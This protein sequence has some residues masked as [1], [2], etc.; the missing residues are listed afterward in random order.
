[1]ALVL[2]LVINFI[3]FGFA[4]STV[5]KAGLWY[6]SKDGIITVVKGFILLWVI[7][8]MRNQATGGGDD[9][10]ITSTIKKGLNIG[11]PAEKNEE[12]TLIPPDES[13][14]SEV[15]VE[16][17]EILTTDEQEML[18]LVNKTRQ[19][20]G[21]NELE[22]DQSL[23]EVARMK[24]RDM[25]ENNYFD[26]D[27]PVFGSPFDMLKKEKIEYALAGENIAE[28]TSIEEAFTSLMDSVEHRDNILKARYDRI[29]IGVVNNGLEKMIIVQIFVDSPEPTM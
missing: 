25:V 20:S 2:I 22:V 16:S 10:L 5:V 18:R 19:E 28:S 3:T 13:P 23:V 26:H 17:N 9:D 14:E 15:V 21:L 24:A 11:Q 29:G 4:G 6:D 12:E 27:S 7:N 8:L 1:M